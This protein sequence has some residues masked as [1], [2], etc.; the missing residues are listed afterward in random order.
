MVVSDLLALRE[1]VGDIAVFA[2]PDVPESLFHALSRITTDGSLRAA[3]AALGPQIAA[4]YSAEECASD[5]AEVYW[6]CHERRHAL[7]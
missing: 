6:S 1:T 4:R 7:A 3:A 2:R 5:H